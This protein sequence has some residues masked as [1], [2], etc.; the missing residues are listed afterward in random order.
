MR[1]RR[2]RKMIEE[3]DERAREFEERDLERV[4]SFI[5]SSMV[6]RLMPTLFHTY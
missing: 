4:Q 1:S 5:Q 6:I 2:G 3:E